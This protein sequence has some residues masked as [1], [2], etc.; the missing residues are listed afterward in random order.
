MALVRR[1]L[2]FVLVAF[3]STDATISDSFRKFIR[4]RFGIAT[5]QLAAR[6]D[7]GWVGSF[8]GGNHVGGRKT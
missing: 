2:L 4:N 5:E 6:D 3:A 1:I 8:G 7:L